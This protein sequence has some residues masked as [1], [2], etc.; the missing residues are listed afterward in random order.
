MYGDFRD[1]KGSRVIKNVVGIGIWSLRVRF[2]DINVGVIS[3][4]FFLIYLRL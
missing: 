1:F 3:I 2:R 4:G